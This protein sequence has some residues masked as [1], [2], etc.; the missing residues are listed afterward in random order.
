MSICLISIGKDRNDPL[1][2]Q[3]HAYLDRVRRS[4]PVQVLELKEEALRKNV[5][6]D[7]VRNKEAERILAKL[8]ERARLV[9]LDGGGKL[10]SSEAWAEDLEETVHVRKL[11]LTMVVGGPVG[12]ARSLL[13][14]A[15]ETRSLGP[16][17]LPHRLARLIVAEQLY[18][19]VTI[20][21]DEPY[22]K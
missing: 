21:N 13:E 12:L 20:L 15:D 16:L 14:R 8:P 9:C 3:T 7:A 1:V 2:Q 4:L 18:R 11:T 6:P 22:H 17:T 19:A 10:R 5:R